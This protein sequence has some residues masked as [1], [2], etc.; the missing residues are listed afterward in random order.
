MRPGS[1]GRLYN[2]FDETSASR[3]SVRSRSGSRCGGG[4]EIFTVEGASRTLADLPAPRGAL[5]E[6]GQR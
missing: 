6:S 5:T 1:A 2:G 4:T 3:T